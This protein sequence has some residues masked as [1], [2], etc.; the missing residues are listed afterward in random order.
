MRARPATPPLTYRSSTNIRKGSLWSVSEDEAK[1]DFDWSHEIAPG[2]VRIELYVAP[3]QID[4]AIS[5]IKPA[6]LA[7]Q[8]I[9]VA[10][11]CCLLAF[12]S[13]VDR[14]LSEPRIRHAIGGRLFRHVER[15]HLRA[16]LCLA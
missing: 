14:S 6:T 7:N 9:K 10:A 8:Q 12:R 3:A 16:L 2:E 11:A 15:Q 1:Y 13:E 5:E 4:A